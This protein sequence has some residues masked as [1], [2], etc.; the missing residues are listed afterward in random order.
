VN[1]P[2]PDGMYGFGL[3][4][5]ESRRKAATT[6]V[7]TASDGAPVGASASRFD[8]FFVKGPRFGSFDVAIDGS[9]VRTIDAHADRTEAASERFTASD[10]AHK[11]AFAATSNTPVRLLGVALERDKP[12]V[13]VDSLGVTSADAKNML[14][15]NDAGVWSAALAKRKYDL[16]VF[17]TGTN[18]FFGPEKHRAI[19][20]SLI[21]LHRAAIPGVSVL[22]LAPPDRVDGAGAAHTTWTLAQTA[23]EKKEIAAEN[24]CAFWD[25]REAM[26]G[27][28]SALEFVRTRKME[29]DKRHFT[30]DGGFWIGDR[31]AFAMWQGFVSWAKKNP[32]AGCG[33]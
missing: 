27:D 8:L 21:D 10:G 24:R 26:G 9:Q 13:I 28:A 23:R 18:E 3:M 17:L 19:M 22:V 11:I 2:A 30:R 4:A 20:K 1:N 12:S 16:V 7:A 33:R 31:L 6:W 15:K 5:A 14:E 32:G 25:T 29:S